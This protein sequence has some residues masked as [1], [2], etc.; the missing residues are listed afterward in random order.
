MFG[1]CAALG[2]VCS[3]AAVQRLHR[4]AAL[5]QLPPQLDTSPTVCAP[6]PASCIPRIQSNP[7][8]PSPASTPA[9]QQSAPAAALGTCGQGSPPQLQQRVQ[10]NF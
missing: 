4:H 3:T 10:R 1:R 9:P 6:V 2:T 7:I 5:Q 8:P